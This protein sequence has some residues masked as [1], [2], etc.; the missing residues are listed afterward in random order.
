MGFNI[1]ITK[2]FVYWVDIDINHIF[3]SM[4]EPL[5]FKHEHPYQL[6]GFGCVFDGIYWWVDSEFD[7]VLWDKF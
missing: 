1:K 3:S 7:I 4:C 5:C 2:E 6:F